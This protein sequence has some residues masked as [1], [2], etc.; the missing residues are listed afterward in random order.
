MNRLFNKLK[1][2]FGK[3]ESRN[4]TETDLNCTQVGFVCRLGHD[5]NRPVPQ[6][7]RVRPTANPLQNSNFENSTGPES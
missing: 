3:Y 6:V 2:E 7:K 5:E 1:T 4:K